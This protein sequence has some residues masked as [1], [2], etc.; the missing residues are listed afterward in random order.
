MIRVERY[1]V[2]AER[3]DVVAHVV[4]AASIAAA[5]LTGER[6]QNSLA[7]KRQ[8]SAIGYLI[9][10]MAQSVVSAQSEP[11]DLLRIAR[12]QAGVA[13][14]RIRPKFIHAAE[15]LIEWTAIGIRRKAACA[16]VLVAIQFYLVWLVKSAGTDE[17]HTHCAFAADLLLHPS[18]VLVVQGSLQG[19]TWKG[20]EPDRQRTN[21]I[22]RSNATARRSAGAE[23]GLQGLVCGGESIDGAAGNSWEDSHATNLSTQGL[24]RSSE[25][26]ARSLKPG[27]RSVRG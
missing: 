9:E 16:D 10:T 1:L 18:T 4:I 5:Q 3:R 21:R 22:S 12:L 24:P 27:R 17:V 14:I 7:G 8:Q 6:R 19:A 11:S 13:A 2:K 20:V 15:A 25:H 23:A 26:R